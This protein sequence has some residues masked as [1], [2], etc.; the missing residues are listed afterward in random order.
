MNKSD[1]ATENGH[2]LANTAH[3]TGLRHG[4]QHKRC[5]C[6]AADCNNWRT[7]RHWLQTFPAMHMCTSI[8]F[9]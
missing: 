2:E 4:L 3:R 9:S 7:E 1:K 5:R 8:A 6:R